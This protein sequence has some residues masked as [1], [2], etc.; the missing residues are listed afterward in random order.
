MTPSSDCFSES[1]FN[2]ATLVD[3]LRFRALHQPDQRAYTFL[4]DGETEEVHLTYRELDQKA[5]AIAAQLQ[6]LGAAG[7]RALCFY[8]PGWSPFP[9]LSSVAFLQRPPPV[10]AGHLPYQGDPLFIFLGT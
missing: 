3:L 9:L 5:Q 6:S 10:V 8:P 4:V 2:P 7:E 1:T